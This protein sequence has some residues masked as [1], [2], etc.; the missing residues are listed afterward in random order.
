MVET[1]FKYPKVYNTSSDIVLKELSHAINIRSFLIM[2]TP[3]L[4]KLNDRCV[5]TV[6]NTLVDLV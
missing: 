4:V 2:L 3:P 6:L 5:L 1:D